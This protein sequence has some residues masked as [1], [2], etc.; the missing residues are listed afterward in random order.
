MAHGLGD[1]GEAERLYRA[2]R[3]GF[4]EQPGGYDAAPVTLDLARRYLE[5]ERFREV[6]HLTVEMAPAFRRRAIHPEAMAALRRPSPLPR[7]AA[8]PPLAY[9]ASACCSRSICC[10]TSSR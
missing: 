3:D 2:V 1:T 10:S 7:A 6:R 5:P 8:G 9:P 4:L